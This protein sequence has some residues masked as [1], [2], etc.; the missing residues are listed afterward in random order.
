MNAVNRTRL[1]ALRT[2]LSPWFYYTADIT[3]FST[4][5]RSQIGPVVLLI[6]RRAASMRFIPGTVRSGRRQAPL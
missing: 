3:F 6:Q 1:I 2:M 5:S 4:I